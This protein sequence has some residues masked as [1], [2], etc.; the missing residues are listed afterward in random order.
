MIIS[1]TEAEVLAAIRTAAE[2]FPHDAITQSACVVAWHRLSTQQT[3][4][5]GCMT[6][7]RR[8]QSGWTVEFHEATEGEGFSFILRDADARLAAARR[9]TGPVQALAGRSRLGVARRTVFRLVRNLALSGSSPR[10]GNSSSALLPV[11][12]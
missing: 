2:V 3:A 7:V 9:C 4:P 1:V 8:N 5:V 10:G 11:D 12:L 6:E